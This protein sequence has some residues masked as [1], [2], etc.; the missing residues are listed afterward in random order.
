MLSMHNTSKKSARYKPNG[1]FASKLIR[2]RENEGKNLPLI[3]HYNFTTR[4]VGLALG[5]ASHWICNQKAREY[6][7]QDDVTEFNTAQIHSNYNPVR[8]ELEIT[9]VDG[10]PIDYHGAKHTQAVVRLV[11]YLTKKHKLPLVK[12]IDATWPRK[13]LKNK[14]PI[15]LKE[16]VDTICPPH[17]R[18]EA[19]KELE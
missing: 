13:E 9:A 14:T 18:K 5:F 10:K 6:T 1:L 3:I 19:R 2:N 15:S 7:R 8:R 17:I 16:A 4:R 12:I 11:E